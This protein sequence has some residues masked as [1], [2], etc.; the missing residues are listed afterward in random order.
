MSLFLSL[1]GISMRQYF[2]KSFS[3]SGGFRKNIKRGYGHIGGLSIEGGF[4]PSA[5]Y[6]LLISTHHTKI[7]VFH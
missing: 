6:S 1:L 3:R 7:E 5:H 4:K 2:R